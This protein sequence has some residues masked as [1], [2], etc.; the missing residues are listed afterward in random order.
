MPSL[1]PEGSDEAAMCGKKHGVQPVILLA[2]HNT[3]LAFTVQAG[4]TVRFEQGQRTSSEA[5]ISFSAG[6]CMMVRATEAL[7]ALHSPAHVHSVWKRQRVC[8]NHFDVH[9]RSTAS[10]ARLSYY[11]EASV[12]A[13][14][15]ASFQA[16][17]AD[18]SCLSLEL[19][20]PVAEH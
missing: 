1:C 10:D 16:P 2:R 9:A 4:N 20:T 13:S 7:H 11:L 6:S 12:A 8:E 14:S 15:C 3:R 5:S 18:N 19:S 17:M